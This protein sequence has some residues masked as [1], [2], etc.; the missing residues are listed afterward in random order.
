MG[1][2]AARD[3]SAVRQGELRI[4]GTAALVLRDNLSR[5]FYCDYNVPGTA[6]AAREAGLYRNNPVNQGLALQHHDPPSVNIGHAGVD[7][8]LIDLAC[9]VRLKNL[10]QIHAET[11]ALALGHSQ[12]DSGAGDELAMRLTRRRVI[13]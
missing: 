11:E 8:L 2:W 5:C 10:G 13:A 4:F 1:C 12:A 6:A 7:A 9:A 3:A